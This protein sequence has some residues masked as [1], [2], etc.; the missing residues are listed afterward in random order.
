MIRDELEKQKD[1]VPF[2][3]EYLSRYGN[4]IATVR[5]VISLDDETLTFY[6]KDGARNTVRLSIIQRVL[7]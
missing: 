4:T 6:D 5:S 1:N 7:G 3:I 2:K